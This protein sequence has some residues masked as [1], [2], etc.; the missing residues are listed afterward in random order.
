L[1][2]EL[3]E[4][5]RVGRDLA[6]VL[7]RLSRGSCLAGNMRSDEP[8]AFDCAERHHARITRFTFSARSMNAFRIAGWARPLAREKMLQLQVA[9]MYHSCPNP[10]RA[11]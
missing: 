11:L 10:G 5:D 6:D 2:A 8:G 1:R 7:D 9:L 4:G 3:R